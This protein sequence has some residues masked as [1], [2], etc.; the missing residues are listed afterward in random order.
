MSK[1]TLTVNAA[2]IN[3]VR[4]NS[5]REDPRLARIR[6]ENA[7]HPCFGMFTTPEQGQFLSFLS[8][9]KQPKKALEIG[10][11]LGYSAL[12]VALK[13]P[14][15]GILYAV[16]KNSEWTNRA[17][18]YWHDAGV[19]EMIKPANGDA[20]P[21]LQTL[22][23]ENHA[24][25]FDFIF[26]DADKRNYKNYYEAAL[27]LAAPGA[28]IIIDNVLWRGT[29]ADPAITDKHALWMREFNAF[30]HSDE[31]VDLSMLTIGDGMTLAIKR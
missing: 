10:V 24:G 17:K 4:E 7:E 30:V 21:F 15:D 20:L 14:K 9:L 29:V 5:L 2:L 31:R 26:I 11:F 23:S 3:Y 22:L 1:E 13:M 18:E 19:A 25:T 28:L 8:Q 27:Q 16:D 6:E 12:A